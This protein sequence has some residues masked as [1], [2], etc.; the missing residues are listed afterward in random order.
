VLAA[1]AGRGATCELH[2][3]GAARV[4]DAG[5]AQPG[6]QL[7]RARER[8]LGAGEDRVDRGLERAARHLLGGLGHLAYDGQDRALDRLAHAA[9]GDVARAAEGAG[10]RAGV[11]HGL[12][13]EGVAEAAQDLREDHA[14]VALR[15]AQRG[16][17][18]DERE[19]LRRR[20]LRRLERAHD[21][22]HRLREVRARVAVRH[23]VDVHVVDPLARRAERGR[24]T[25]RDGPHAREQ[26]GGV[27]RAA[28]VGTS[29]PRR[30]APPPR[31]GG[32]R[33]P[34]APSAGG[35]AGRASREWSKRPPSAA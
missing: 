33:R 21:A 25:G 24:G 2:E 5:L 15:A 9:I 13:A 34:A 35:P 1:E 32:T 26:R 23:R 16:V 29:V 11:E 22:R 3:A 12:A 18:H 10:E 30:S 20:R 7:G 31:C 8:L 19:P 27:G 28:H 17:A 6:E 14:G 4:D